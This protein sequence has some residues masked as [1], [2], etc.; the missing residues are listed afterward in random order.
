MWYYWE[1]VK[2]QETLNAMLETYNAS[3]ENVEVKPSM[4]LL[5]ISRSRFPLARLPMC[6]PTL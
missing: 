4:Y 5:P 1:T 6:S 3:Q 2:H